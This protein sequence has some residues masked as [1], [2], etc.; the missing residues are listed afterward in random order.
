MT[1]VA[2]ALHRG[3]RQALTARGVC[4][5]WILSV[6]FAAESVPREKCAWD[7]RADLVHDPAQRIETVVPNDADWT[8][9]ATRRAE[10]ATLVQRCAS[11]A[12]V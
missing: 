1:E 4:V 12:S 9:S 7:Q 11:A 6:V 5:A 2:E 3:V 10:A 8:Q